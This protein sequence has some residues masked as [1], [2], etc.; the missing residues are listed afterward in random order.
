MHRFLMYGLF[1]MQSDPYREMGILVQLAGSVD[2][3]H[4][5]TKDWENAASRQHTFIL[6]KK[7]RQ[8]EEGGGESQG[9]S[10]ASC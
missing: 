3:N 7:G 8:E 10:P 5:G 1:G 4:A 9:S 2:L 6:R